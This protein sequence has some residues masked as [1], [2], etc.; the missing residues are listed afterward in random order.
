M[1]TGLN[2]LTV[3]KLLWVIYIMYKKLPSSKIVLE[4]YTHLPDMLTVFTVKK[5]VS[6]NNF[7]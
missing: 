4:N 7:V 5:R 3:I 6:R 1:D 2:F